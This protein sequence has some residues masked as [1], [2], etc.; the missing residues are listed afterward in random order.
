MNGSDDR[1]TP[2]IGSAL[3][4]ARR[5]AGMDVKEAEERTKIRARYL[6]ALEAEDWEVLPA[7]AYIR[8]FLRT[9]GEILGIDGEELADEYRRRYEASEQ[10]SQSAASEPLL[11]ERRRAPGSRPPSRTPLILAIAA[12]I[13]ILLVIL[14]SIGGDDG[15]EGP[16]DGRAAR[17]LRDDARRGEPREKLEPVGVTL[18]PL[19]AVMVCLVGDGEEALIDGQV[20]AAG[21]EESFDGFKTYRLDLA[22]GGTVKVRSAGERERIEADG[23]VSYEADSRGIREIEYA[24]PECP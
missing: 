19:G 14:G 8:G 24:G 11:S 17:K 2:G 4:D 3:K 23:E 12:G 10:A 9:Y 7:P 6:R 16:T 18:E 13:I 5:R 15:D 22:E 21:A 1:R 20:L